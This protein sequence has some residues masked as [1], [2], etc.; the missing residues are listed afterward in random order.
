MK[1]I[2]INNPEIKNKIY[3]QLKKLKK[4]R[5]KVKKKKATIRMWRKNM[6]D[7]L[8]ESISQGDIFQTLLTI[9]A[10]HFFKLL[11]FMNLKIKFSKKEFIFKIGFK[12]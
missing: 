7:L 1:F 5:K 6:F 12:F 8:I 9:G 11:S 4:E 10:C 2:Q 3:S